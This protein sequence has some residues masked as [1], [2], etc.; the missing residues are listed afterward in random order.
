MVREVSHESA[1]F[2]IR[3]QGEALKLTVRQETFPGT[4]LLGDLCNKV[5]SLTMKH[6]KKL[7][8]RVPSTGVV[9][10]TFFA[11]KTCPRCLALCCPHNSCVEHLQIDRS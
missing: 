4:F 2:Q 6:K 7:G 3:L 11:V 9:L 1:V 8:T 5:C 10:S